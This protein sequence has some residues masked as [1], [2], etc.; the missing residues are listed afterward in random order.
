VAQPAE[1]AT[2]PLPPAAVAP[3]AGHPEPA[4]LSVRAVPYCR[5]LLLDEVSLQPPYASIATTP[6]RH[7]L[8]CV[9]PDATRELSVSLSP[10]RNPEVVVRVFAD[11]W[12]DASALTGQLFVDGHACGARCRAPVGAVALELRAGDRVLEQEPLFDLPPGN[13]RL[14]ATP[15]R[16]Q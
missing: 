7:H 9:H 6:G 11:A 10:G 5:P 15:L 3:D 2:V 13:C 14:A 4:L 8:R 16:C 12:V 1:V